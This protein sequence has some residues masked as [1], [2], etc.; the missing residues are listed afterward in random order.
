MTGPALFT[1]SEVIVI[2]K[3][4]WCCSA[5]C[6]HPIVRVNVQWLRV[7]QLANTPPPSQSTIPGLHPVSIHQTSP[8]ACEEANIRLQLTTKFI[9]LERMKG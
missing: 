4:Q 2:G 1:I 5:N 6:D 7:M 8:H 9:D 3:S